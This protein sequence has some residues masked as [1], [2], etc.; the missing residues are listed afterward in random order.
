VKVLA[1]GEYCPED[2]EKVA[3]RFRQAMAERQRGSVK[4]PKMIFP[5]HGISGESKTVMVYDDPT[6]EQLNAL[7]IHYLPVMTFKFMPL[8]EATKFIEQYN[9]ERKK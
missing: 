4:F 9:K 1:F 2:F 6:E 3:E 7:V 8:L 5:P